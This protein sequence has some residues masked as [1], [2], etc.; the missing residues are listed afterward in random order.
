MDTLAGDILANIISQVP[1][2]PLVTNAKHMMLTEVCTWLSI[3]ILLIATDAGKVQTLKKCINLWDAR[4]RSKFVRASVPLDAGDGVLSTLALSCPHIQKLNVT[5]KPSPGLLPLKE[6]TYLQT[7]YLQNCQ[8]LYGVFSEG[9]CAKLHTLTLAGCFDLMDISLLRHCTELTEFALSGCYHFVDISPLTKCRKLE[10]LK[11]WQCKCLSDLQPL[12]EST[13]LTHL[14]IRW[15]VSLSDVGPLGKCHSLT[16]LDL[17]GCNGV[18]DLC[19]LVGLENLTELDLSYTEAND[20][21]PLVEL[22]ELTLLDLTR[23]PVIDLTPLKNPK[24]K[25][26]MIAECAHIE[27]RDAQVTAF[28]QRGCRVFPKIVNCFSG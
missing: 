19:G 20:L 9:T 24:L 22:P 3:C 11:F 6:F 27:D 8:S 2:G 5:L 21:T 7:L 18:T 1:E 17:R 4:R 26:L 12:C 14:G 25:Q 10:K 16:Q 13:L 23:T 15:C 28:I